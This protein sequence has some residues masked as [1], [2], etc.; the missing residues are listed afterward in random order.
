MAKEQKSNQLLQHGQAWL[1]WGR[2]G[3]RSHPSPGRPCPHPR[4][5][6]ILTQAGF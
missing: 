6:T 4:K 3:Q 2:W 1:H 5:L